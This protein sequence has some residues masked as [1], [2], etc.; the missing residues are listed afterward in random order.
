MLK[1][2]SRNLSAGNTLKQEVDKYITLDDSN[3]L[4]SASIRKKVKSYGSY[5][6]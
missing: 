5:R 1:H 2:H 6:V 4:D 3:R